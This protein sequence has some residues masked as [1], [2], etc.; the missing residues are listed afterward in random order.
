MW[1]LFIL[2]LGNMQAQAS[3]EPSIP[4]ALTGD[5]L[6]G[7]STPA[8]TTPWWR[9]LGDA[10]LDGLMKEALSEAPD[11]KAA[12]ARVQ[13]ARAMSAQA[14][15]GLLPDL[16]LD[17]TW[18]TQPT[19]SFGF[20]FQALG[21][22]G[23]IS[24]PPATFPSTLTSPTGTTTGLPD[25]EIPEPEPLPDLFHSG[26]G[27][28]TARWNLDITGRQTISWRASHLEAQANSGD[29][30]AMAIALSTQVG[31]LYY[32]IVTA[33]EQ[34]RILFEQRAAQEQL[35]A[36]ME[37][38][39]TTGNASAVQVLQQRQRVASVA[40]LEP[41]ARALVT[42]QRRSLNILLGREMNAD[43]ATVRALPELPPSPSLGQPRDLMTHRPDV[44]AA[45]YRD[46]AARQR[47]TV[48]L[49][50]LAPTLGASAS[51]GRQYTYVEELDDQAFW[52]AGAQLSVPL[53]SGGARHAGVRSARANQDAAEA[54]L[55]RTLHTAR[56]EVESAIELDQARKE[57]LE[58]ALQ[59]EEAARMLLE[60]SK[61]RYLAGLDSYL[62]V[63]AAQDASL[64]ASLARVQAHRD[65]L[66]ARIQLHDALGGPW[67][68][69]WNHGALP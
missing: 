22:A 1:S 63:L 40:A 16:S 59:G 47:S 19:S 32:G 14:V 54:E 17:A 42:A 10:T 11:L 56:S 43:M 26:Q 29:H 13:S 15:A 37:S 50:E 25:F 28:L 30:A 8:S 38:R 20:S 46:K 66:S 55:R 65:A 39:Y 6:S 12:W 49:L 27:A 52:N 31:E 53:V 61:K 62:S 34:H 58:L 44:R 24:A 51:W 21:F 41:P 60:E 64:S 36:L 2:L 3:D 35:L 23:D 67:L 18:N 9:D 69:T 48:A 5:Y 4:Q 7:S 68:Q 45:Q 57:A 33:E